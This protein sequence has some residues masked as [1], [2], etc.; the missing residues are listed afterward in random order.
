[1]QA[2]F[3]STDLTVLEWAKLPAAG[4]LVFCGAAKM[5]AWNWP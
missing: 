5:T 1:M 4:L 2:I 3:D